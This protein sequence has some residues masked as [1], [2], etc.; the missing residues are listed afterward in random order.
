MANDYLKQKRLLLVDD[1]EEL[2][3]MVEMIL[4]RDG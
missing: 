4:R 2:L 3:H 1:E